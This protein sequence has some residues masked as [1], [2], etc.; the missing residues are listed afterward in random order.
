MLIKILKLTNA[1]DIIG[2]FDE[3][4]CIIKKPAK[5]VMFS[6]DEGEMGMG[7]MPWIPFSDDEEIDIRKDCIM[8]VIN[9]STDIKNEYNTKFGS[10]LITPP[11]EIIT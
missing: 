6:T 2:D 8:T 4:K 10:G 3:I 7:M 5:L 11:Q 1:E 9:P